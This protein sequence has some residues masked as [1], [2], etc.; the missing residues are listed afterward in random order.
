MAI[1][2]RSRVLDEV[3][4]QRPAMVTALADLIRTPSQTGTAAEHEAQAAMASALAADG[5]EVDHWELPLAELRSDPD[6]P[7]TE[8][9]RTEGW[10]VVGRLPGS[11]SGSDGGRTLLL[12]GHID[13]VPPGDPA[14]WTH[15]DPYSGE[16]T[17]TEV[18]G[19]GACDMKGGLLA[20]RWAV[21]ALAATGVPLAGD[22]LLASVEG[23]EDGGLGTF[24]LLRRG[25]TADVCVVPEP[26]ALDLVPACAGALTFRL[27]I[28]GRAAHAS[29]RTEGVSAIEKLVPVLAALAALETERNVGADPLLDRWGIAYPLSL[30]VVRAGDWASTVPDLLEA[31]GRLGVALD[32]DPAVAQA[33]LEAAVAE[34]CAADPWLRQHPVEVEWW[35]GQFASGRLPSESDL[36]E[37]VAAHH[38]EVTG[39]PAATWAGPFGSDLR[40]LTGLGGIPTVHYGPGDVDLAHAPDEAVPLA[41]VEVTARVLALLALEVC[42]PR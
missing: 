27:R 18:R 16:L 20:A 6:F 21:R 7:G 2:W 41:E 30:G 3:G 5:L 13:V 33:A 24:G 35:G 9:P 15:P 1:D 36:G 12:D 39:A 17:A 40:L 31:E 4:A 19:R 29:R 42:G 38:H 8:A 11:G 14:T 37:R 10:G 23:E 22:V 32:E 25:W 34:A 28:R 26:T